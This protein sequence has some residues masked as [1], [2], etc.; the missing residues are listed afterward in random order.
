MEN[1]LS[2]TAVTEEWVSNNLENCRKC[3]AY[4]RLYP[5]RF[6]EEVILVNNPHD[7]KL[8]SYQRII[9]RQIFRNRN[10]F[11]TMSRG[12]SKSFTSI[13]GMILLCV[14][15]PHIYA[16]IAAKDQK[17]V[18]SIMQEN[19]N[20]LLDMIPALKDEIDFTRGASVMSREKTELQFHNGSILSTIAILEGTK[21]VRRNVLM[22][23]EAA[24]YDEKKNAILADAVLPTLSVS[25][26]LA[27]G[28]IHPEEL[29]NEKI[30]WSTSAG[31]KK[32]IPYYRLIQNYIQSFLEDDAA[33]IEASWKAPVIVGL[34]SERFINDILTDPTYG[35]VEA[36][37]NFLSIWGGENTNGYFNITDLEKARVLKDAEWEKSDKINGTNGYYVI[38]V[39][40]GRLDDK[41][42]AMI[43][44]VTPVKGKNYTDK[45]IVNNYTLSDKSFLEQAI[46]IKQLY[47]KYS[48]QMIVVDVNGPGLVL[49]ELLAQPQWEYALPSF[50]ICNDEEHHYDKFY[51]N[52]GLIQNVIFTMKANQQINSS[53]YSYVNSQLAQG[54]IKLLIGEQ[55]GKEHLNRIQATKGLSATEKIDLT[56]PYI[57][58]TQLIEQMGNLVQKQGATTSIA[59]KQ[60]ISRIKKDKV[61]ALCYGMYWIMQQEQQE[62]LR[63]SLLAYCLF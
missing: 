26:R 22:L 30:I 12:S 34:Q 19:I 52:K 17:Q 21:G 57:R 48:P 32:T 56:I 8:Y 63:Q 20:K 38:G 2:L 43:I 35:T 6:L 46:V 60:N 29:C 15:Y 33:H 25:R 50:S 53:M 45:K 14:L 28:S 1:N 41:F 9:L 10:I 7:F 62:V 11:I 58:T 59:L 24:S 27:D 44:K 31:M 51:D 13:L 3:I 54:R 18:I 16:S 40:C 55:A 61:S 42:E 49:S 47:F 23:D 4:Y 36:R 39:D 5:D 37:K